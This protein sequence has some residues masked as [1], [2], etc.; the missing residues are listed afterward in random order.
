MTCETCKSAIS[1]TAIT[2]ERS[3]PSAWYRAGQLI[4]K[5]RRLGIVVHWRPALIQKYPP[6]SRWLRPLWLPAAIGARIPAAAASWHSDVTWFVKEMVSSLVTL[7]PFTR[8]PRVLDVDDAIWLQRGGDFARRLAYLVDLVVAGNE[9]LAE[10]FADYNENVV[11]IPTAV[12][13]EL[14]RPPDWPHASEVRVIGWIGSSSNLHEL[15]RI[16]GALRDVLAARKNSVLLIICDEVPA[17]SYLPPG[18]VVVARWRREEEVRLIQEMDIGIMPLTDSDWCRGKCA[19]K[20]LQYLACGRAVV[21]SPVGVNAAVLEGSGGLV[22]KTNAEWRDA[23]VSLIDNPD[24]AA[25]IGKRGRELVDSQFSAKTIARQLARCFF[26][27]RRS[28]G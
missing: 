9:F 28:A 17:F 16:E 23:L 3:V 15:Y 27:L 10:W 14:F 26:D 13:T 18:R 20:L 6:R 12:D 25:A 7:E 24:L 5:L 21:A 4:S 11:V 22:A 8:A 2:A 19:F 1:V